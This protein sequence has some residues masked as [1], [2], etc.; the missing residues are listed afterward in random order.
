VIAL[1]AE[2]STEQAILNVLL[3]HDVLKFNR[4]S[5]AIKNCTEMAI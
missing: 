4:M 5:R 2:G 1:L 3:D